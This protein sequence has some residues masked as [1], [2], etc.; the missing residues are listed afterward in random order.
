M[1]CIDVRAKARR[2][3]VDYEALRTADIKLQKA[4]DAFLIEHKR[5]PKQDDRI[6]AIKA[7]PEREMIALVRMDGWY[8]RRPDVFTWDGLREGA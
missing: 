5:F 7:L 1:T 8:R 4:M 6:Q 2:L 3:G